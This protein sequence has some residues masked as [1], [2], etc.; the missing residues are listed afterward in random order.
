MFRTTVLKKYS[1]V[2]IVFLGKILKATTKT[3]RLRF[4][5]QQIHVGDLVE[6]II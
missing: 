5:P 2:M 1:R 3:K 6:I 4:L